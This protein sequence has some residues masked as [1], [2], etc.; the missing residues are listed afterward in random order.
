[1]GL[2]FRARRSAK[3]KD[4]AAELAITGVGIVVSRVHTPQEILVYEER[5]IDAPN[6]R[7]VES[8]LSRATRT[9][10]EQQRR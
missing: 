7:V 3:V 6:Q 1:M 8:R 5:F 2:P 10:Q 9:S 4:Q